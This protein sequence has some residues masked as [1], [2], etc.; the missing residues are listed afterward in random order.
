MAVDAC[1][2]RFIP[3]LIGFPG[4]EQALPASQVSKIGWKTGSRDPLACVLS[5]P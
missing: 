2:T 4:D 3:T 1:W 5:F